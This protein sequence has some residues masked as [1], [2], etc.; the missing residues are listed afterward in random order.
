MC[1][2]DYCNSLLFSITDD[3]LRRLQPVQN[4]AARLVLGALRL[5]HIT[6]VLRQLHWLR[7]KQRVE[8]KL[9]VLTQSMNSCRRTWLENVSWSHWS[10]LHDVAS[11]GRPTFRRSSSS[12]RPR[13]SAT[14][15]SVAP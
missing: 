2:L 12:A 3:L 5:D 13:V 15:D 7:V 9:A 11:L 10:Q 4:A 1:R 8:Y 6:P 14:D